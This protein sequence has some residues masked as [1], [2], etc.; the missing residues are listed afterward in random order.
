MTR[1]LANQLVEA[2]ENPNDDLNSEETMDFEYEKYN[3]RESTTQTG[4]S[5][6]TTKTSMMIKDSSPP[7]TPTVQ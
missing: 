4:L 2:L 5:S 3:F 6:V 7:T 1:I